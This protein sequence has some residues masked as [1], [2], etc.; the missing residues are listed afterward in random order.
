MTDRNR[1]DEQR[2]EQGQDYRSG[3]QSG[4]DENW[5]DRQ[6]HQ[7]DMGGRSGSYASRPWG[8]SSSAQQGGSY[9][10]EDYRDR[11][12]ARRGSGE[13][14]GASGY[15]W[16]EQGDAGRSS[17]SHDYAGTRD[18]GGSDWGGS[19]RG[20]TDWR[21]RDNWRNA[22]SQSFASDYGMRDGQNYDER[23][24][25][26]GFGG[27]GAYSNPGYDRGYGPDYGRDRDDGDYAERARSGRSERGFFERAGDEIASWFGDEEASR[28]REQDYRG[29]GPSDYTR[30]DERIREDVNDRLT[31]DPRVDARRIS[32]A[33]DKGEVTLSGTVASREAKRRAEDVI[34]R[35]SGVKHVQNNLRVEERDRAGQSGSEGWQ[36]SYTTKTSTGDA[37]MDAGT[38]TG[39]G[40]YAGNSGG[41]SGIT[42]ESTGSSGASATG[43][44][45]STTVPSTRK[46]S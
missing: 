12:R 27:G 33:V 36:R 10:Y 21:S 11:D 24:R 3:Q 39:T 15:G 31:D 25:R 37:A 6:Q 2:R 1:W 4:W 44:S 45:G 38:G 35:V 28:R 41:T 23:F 19:D 26:Q 34:D 17:G 8:G 32:V 20:G 42:G 40:P 30:S 14:G 46:D 9:D 43:A 7:R 5:R 29:H 16:S 18:W 22:G 13:M